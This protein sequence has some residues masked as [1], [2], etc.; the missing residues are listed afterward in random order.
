MHAGGFLPSTNFKNSSL[1]VLGLVGQLDGTLLVSLEED[2]RAFYATNTNA[3][4]SKYVRVP[5][6]NHGE[7]FG[8]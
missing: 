2:E 3:S 4:V 7:I 6:T 5:G 8:C 1:P